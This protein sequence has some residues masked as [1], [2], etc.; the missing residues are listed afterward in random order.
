MYLTEEGTLIDPSD[1][2]SMRG[3]MQKLQRNAT[4]TPIMVTT[5]SYSFYSQGTISASK[6]SKE[7]SVQISRYPMCNQGYEVTNIYQGKVG[8][9]SAHKIA[10]VYSGFCR[11]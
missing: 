9:K 5:F 11:Y 3:G 10:N 4:N 1:T 7:L 8:S 2:D 6:V